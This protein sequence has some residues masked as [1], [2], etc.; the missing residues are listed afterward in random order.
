MLMGSLSRA[1]ISGELCD[2]W[3]HSKDDS[4]ELDVQ[5]ELDQLTAVRLPVNWI[6]A[7]ALPV[8]GPRA[9]KRKRG[10]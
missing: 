7:P 9:P 10:V 2:P 1:P 6:D 4:V 3:L 8:S 5:R